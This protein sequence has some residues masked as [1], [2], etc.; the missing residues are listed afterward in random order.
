MSSLRRRAIAVHRAR[1]IER[2]STGGRVTRPDDRRR[3]G[4][5]GEHPQPGEDVAHLGTLEQGGVAGEAERHPALLERRGH[6]ARLAPPGA[7]DHADGLGP[8][9]AGREQVLDLPR[10]GLGLARARRYSART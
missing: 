7:D 10:R 2:S 4:G 6:Q 8:H 9:L 3:I 5:I 1:S